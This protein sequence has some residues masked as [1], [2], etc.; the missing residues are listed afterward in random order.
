MKKLRTPISYYGGKQALLHHI[1]PLIPPHEV[2]TETFFG[3]GAVFWAKPPA[4]N[5]T[6]NDK[7]D[8]VVNFYRVLKTQF[9]K[10]KPLIE[11]SLISR[12]MHK[13]A[14]DIIRAHKK[15]IKQDRIQLAWAFWLCTNFSHS[16]KLT[17]GV[18]FSNR[19]DTTIPVTL[20]NKKNEFTKFLVSRIENAHIEKKDALFILRSRNVETAFHFQDPPYYN[21]DQ[22]HYKGYTLEDYTALLEW[23]A[24]ECTGKFILTSYPSEILTQYIK[25]NNWNYKEILLNLQAGPKKGRTG[26]M[27]TEVIVWNY[28]L[29]PTLFDQQ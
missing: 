21:A 10:L 3:G 17:G 4:K 22:G 24:K 27:K 5:E 20:R 18:K 28:Q 26:R 2:Y 19:V 15:G 6:I 12:A 9:K 14:G 16:N 1:L 11:Q 7:L 29:T 25:E 8:V 13:E 23:N